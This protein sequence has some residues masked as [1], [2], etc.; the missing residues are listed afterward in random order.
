M[1]HLTRNEKRRERLTAR[2]TAI[3][4]AYDLLSAKKYKEV[5]LYTEDV[6]LAKLADQFFLSEKTIEDIVFDR[7]QY[8]QPVVQLD[9]FKS[10][11]AE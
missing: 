5:R 10:M 11:A 2:N 9:L 1:Q 6:K 8:L 3:K 7:I 4:K